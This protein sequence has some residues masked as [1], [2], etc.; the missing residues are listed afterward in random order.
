LPTSPWPAELRER[1]YRLTPEPDERNRFVQL[2]AEEAHHLYQQLLSEPPQ[3]P[4][5]MDEREVE[6][7]V[8]AMTFEFPDDGPGE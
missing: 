1:G 4:T 2:K 3:P 6:E 8:K 7:W 5:M